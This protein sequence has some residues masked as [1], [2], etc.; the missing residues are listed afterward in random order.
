MRAI[1][2]RRWIARAARITRDDERRWGTKMRSDE[3]RWETTGGRET[4]RDDGVRLKTNDEHYD[5]RPNRRKG[6]SKEKEARREKTN[7]GNDD[8]RLETINDD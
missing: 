1:A 7:D 5:W 4:T 8:G 6:S 2:D 3:R